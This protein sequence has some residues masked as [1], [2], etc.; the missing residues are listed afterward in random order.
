MSIKTKILFL[1]L[2]ALPLVCGCFR[3]S[4]KPADS[5]EVLL[6]K[7]DSFS[8]IGKISCSSSEHSSEWM[9]PLWIDVKERLG[10]VNALAKKNSSGNIEGFWGIDI[11]CPEPEHGKYIAGVESAEG[12]SAPAGWQKY[13]IPEQK[14]FMVKCSGEAR[15]YFYDRMANG[16]IPQGGYELAGGVLEFYPASNIENAVYLYFPVKKAKKVKK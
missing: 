16:F 3:Y 12:A 6:T 4:F 2:T 14:Y 13:V 10:E 5:N 9:I 11:E 15:E 8:V 7:K 1:I